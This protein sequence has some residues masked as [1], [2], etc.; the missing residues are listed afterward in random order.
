MQKNLFV[1]Q[2]PVETVS[3]YG[4][5][6]RD[7]AYSLLKIIN[8]ENWEF[9]IIPTRWGDTP[10]NF[11]NPDISEH[12]LLLD[13]FLK[14]SINRQ[15][16]IFFQVTIPN[17]ATPI[18]KFSILCTAGIETNM[19]SAEWIAG[20]NK[21]DMIIVPSNH[22]KEVFEKTTW[23]QVGPNNQVMGTLKIEK[24]IE[25]LFEGI[26]EKIFKKKESN[27]EIIDQIKEKFC[28]LNVGHWVKGELG[29]D[30]KDVGTL[31]KLFLETFA[32]I[33]NAP[34][35]ILKTSSATF[36]IIDRDQILKNI[37]QIRN[38]VMNQMN[39]PENKMPNIYLL[40]GSLTDEEM[41]E[42]YNHEKVK[43]FITLTK[44]E[45]YGRPMAE[46]SVT[47]KPIIASGWS[48]QL[49]F[50][51]KNHCVLLPG[52]LQKI[53]PSSVWQNVLIPESSWFYVDQN[54]T[55]E[56]LKDCWKRYDDYSRI[57]KKQAE[58]IKE[59]TLD[60]MTEKLDIMLEQYLPKFPKQI[61]IVLPE[62]PNI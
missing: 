30:R 24:P 43:A 6:S 49:D 10:K 32:G 44:G 16:D 18:G 36:S 62:L 28:Y 9:V 52:Q 11:L 4:A 14:P 40:H 41:N 45:G 1:F 55:K 34:A 7:L 58:Y 35:L 33:G 25:V 56:I 51:N 3:G 12:K 39:L 61:E 8:E 5:H 38:M 37:E 48:G 17:E 59:F 57:S 23:N 53:H 21:M 2:G 15:P 54:V 20:M 31:V 13:H 47:G 46:F 60:K 26:D 50:L 27:L 22:A 19:C 29:H 42:L